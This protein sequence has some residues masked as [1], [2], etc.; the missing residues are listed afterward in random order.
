MRISVISWPVCSNRDATPSFE[1]SAMVRT[2][3]SNQF[4]RSLEGPFVCY[5]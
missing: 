1:D 3:K 2:R 4:K 5:P